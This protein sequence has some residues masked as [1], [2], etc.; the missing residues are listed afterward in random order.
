MLKLMKKQFHLTIQQ[1]V[2]REEELISHNI[3]V[4]EVYLLI[5]LKCTCVTLYIFV[6][7]I[8]HIYTFYSKKPSNIYKPNKDMN[9]ISNNHTRHTHIPSNSTIPYSIRTNTS[10]I[11]TTLKKPRIQRTSPTTLRN[12]IRRDP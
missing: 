2:H 3:L 11:H 12:S 5:G 9:L 1:L 6:D 10:S 4:K 8:L 7:H